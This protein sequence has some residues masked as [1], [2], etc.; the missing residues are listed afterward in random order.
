MAINSAVYPDPNQTGEGHLDSSMSSSQL[1]G[2]FL[3]AHTWDVSR[4]TVWMAHQ[5]DIHIFSAYVFVGVFAIFF[6]TYL[7]TYLFIYSLTYLLTVVLVCM[8]DPLT[9]LLPYWATCFDIH[10]RSH[11][12]N[13]LL[14]YIIITYQPAWQPNSAIVLDAADSFQFLDCLSDWSITLWYQTCSLWLLAHPVACLLNWWRTCLLSYFIHFPHSLTHSCNVF[15][16]YL[17]TYLLDC[18]LAC[19]LACLVTDSITHSLTHLLISLLTGV[20]TYLL[21]YILTS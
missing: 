5:P 13:C 10:L 15:A 19:S 11:F 14:I 3:H 2:C 4:P 12:C 18:L 1:L 16:T 9:Q 21:T 8:T 17:L 7:L 6:T 20:L